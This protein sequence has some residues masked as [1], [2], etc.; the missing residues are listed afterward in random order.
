MSKQLYL[1]VYVPAAIVTTFW[2]GCAFLEPFVWLTY[3]SGF[4]QDQP[5]LGL[6]GWYAVVYEIIL[7]MACYFPAVVAACYLTATNPLVRL[8]DK[9]FAE[10]DRPRW[11]WTDLLVSAFILLSTPYLFV[12]RFDRL[13]VMYQNW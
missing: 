8:K 9:T 1:F 2:V 11:F 3:E 13:A 6:E 7:W 12:L 10:R 4:R 5:W